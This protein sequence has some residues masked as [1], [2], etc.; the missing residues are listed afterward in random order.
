MTQRP[1]IDKINSITPPFPN[2]IF[3]HPNVTVFSSAIVPTTAMNFRE[4]RLVAQW[5]MAM[6]IGIVM[7]LERWSFTVNFSLISGL[8]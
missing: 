7:V 4:K 1:I 5:E 8:S 3:A 2:L 6:L